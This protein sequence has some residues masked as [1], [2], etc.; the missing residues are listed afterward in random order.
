M[1]VATK[2][3]PSGA[4][5]LSPIQPE[6]EAVTQRILAALE[7]PVAKSVT[8]LIT[9]G[10]KRL[11]PALVLLAGH[12][13]PSPDRAGLIEAAAAVELI[14]TATL[15][16]DDIIDR[17]P[18]RRNQPT[19]HYRWGTE[20]AVLM[21]DYLYA[22]A[23][24]MIAGLRTPEIMRIMARVCQE[25]SRGELHE[26]DARFRLHLTEADY[27]SII[28]DKTASLIAGCCRSGALLGGYAPQA[29]E[30]WGTFGQQF[31]MAFQ[32]TDDCLDLTGSAEEL[33]KSMHAD[34]DKGVVSLPIIYLAEGL[35]PA[36]RAKLFGRSTGRAL[37][38]A[39]LA[40][41]MRAAVRGGAVARAEARA[42]A[43]GEQAREALR[44]VPSNGLAETVGALAAYA[45]TRRN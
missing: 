8:Y 20:R 36:Q 26:V 14:H 37:S 28:A 35:S 10:G 19:F 42:R 9:A 32:I 33:G 5:D 39:A 13:G 3:Q 29:V 25:L 4:L 43:L 11:R 7:D 38:P 16:H 22:T 40:R 15:I 24:T 30:S 23:F 2:A 1:T 6:L 45:T 17:S 41:I 18:T 12:T 27:F 34:L 44:G 21:G 31:G